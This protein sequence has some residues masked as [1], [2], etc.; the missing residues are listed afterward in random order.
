MEGWGCVCG[1]EGVE[2]V[3]CR[4]GWSMT[5]PNEKVY[6]IKGK[7]QFQHQTAGQFQQQPLSEREGMEESRR[8]LQSRGSFVVLFTVQ[9]CTTARVKACDT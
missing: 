4:G 8:Q 6:R 2:D 1:Y 9:K 3:G 7:A 5:H